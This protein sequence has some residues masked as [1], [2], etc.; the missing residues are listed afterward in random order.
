MEFSRKIADIDEASPEVLHRFSATTAAIDT[1]SS[2]FNATKR[3]CG[4]SSINSDKGVNCAELGWILS[5]NDILQAQ[6]ALDEKCK[7]TGD[8]FVPAHGGRVGVFGNAIVYLCNMSSDDQHCVASN[9]DEAISAIQTQCSNAA[10]K[11]SQI[12]LTVARGDML[13]E[14]RLVQ[15]QIQVSEFYPRDQGALTDSQ[16]GVKAPDTTMSETKFA[17]RTR[18]E[19]TVSTMGDHVLRSEAEEQSR[20]S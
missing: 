5:G 19:R 20:W 13:T 16:T 18:S 10:G 7:A 1:S 6:F 12:R 17:R 4:P 3:C 11:L 9:V 8:S 15:P 14:C 2:S